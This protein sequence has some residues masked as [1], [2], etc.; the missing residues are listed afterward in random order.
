MLHL[1][2]AEAVRL[3]DKEM[4]EA[5]GPTGA[6]AGGSNHNL[7]EE[8]AVPPALIGL[9]AQR[10]QTG[11]LER[12]LKLSKLTEKKPAAKPAIV[13]LTKKTDKEKTAVLQQCLNVLLE[14]A[15]AAGDGEAVACLLPSYDLAV[16]EGHLQPVLPYALPAFA[17][18]AARRG[19]MASLAALKKAGA[20]EWTKACTGDWWITE[21]LGVHERMDCLSH[22]QAPPPPPPPPL[23]TGMTAASAQSPPNPAEGLL[24][25]G[26]DSLVPGVHQPREAIVLAAKR[27][28]EQTLMHLLAG[29]V[30]A[31]DVRRVAQA[32][33][34]EL[35]AALIGTDSAPPPNPAKDE[36]AR[37]SLA[38]AAAFLSPLRPARGAQRPGSA[39]YHPSRRPGSAEY[40]PSRRP[41][42]AEYH[43]S[44]RHASREQSEE[45]EL[46]RRAR[47]LLAGG[48]G[49]G[50]A[51]TRLGFGSSARLGSLADGG[52]PRRLPGSGASSGYLLDAGRGHLSNAHR[53]PSTLAEVN[54]GLASY[55][56]TLTEI[57]VSL[58]DCGV[59]ARGLAYGL[60]QRGFRSPSKTNT[61]LGAELE[62]QLAALSSRVSSLRD[63]TVVATSPGRTSP[64]KV[65]PPLQRPASLGGSGGLQSG[66]STS[67]PQ[68]W[69]QS[70]GL[71][72]SSSGA[73]LGSGER[74]RTA[75]GW[76]A[77]RSQGVALVAAAPRPE[78]VSAL[79]T[80]L[81]RYQGLEHA[82][83]DIRIPRPPAPAWRRDW[84]SEPAAATTITS[85]TTRAS[86]GAEAA[87]DEKLWMELLERSAGLAPL[88]RMA[89]LDQHSH[90]LDAYFRPKGWAPTKGAAGP[91][92]ARRRPLDLGP[93]PTAAFE[94]VDA[95][96]DSEA[97]QLLRTEL[98]TEQ[99]SPRAE[100]S[101]G[102]RSGQLHRP[103]AAAGS[104]A[105]APRHAARPS[106]PPQ[107]APQ[108]QLRV[109]PQLSSRAPPAKAFAV[110]GAPTGQLAPFQGAG[111]GVGQGVGGADWR[112]S[113]P[114]APREAPCSSLVGE[115]EAWGTGRGARAAEAAAERSRMDWGRAEWDDTQRASTLSELQAQQR[116]FEQQA[117]WLCGAPA[118]PAR[119]AGV[120]H[121]R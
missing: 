5:F 34:L 86:G 89:H 41:G 32:G 45:D 104:R 76:Q 24:R 25:E 8:A 30:D 11:L 20:V 63:G 37:A 46:L 87:A 10:G 81:P 35:L 120:R 21:Q 84:E 31:G 23:P 62:A 7:E 117:P 88:E 91:K 48:P 108:V 15:L 85:T 17:A 100:Q 22:L 33:D 107:V 67:G 119:S 2:L 14:A 68:S 101:S 42:S 72:G 118:Q 57:N 78:V 115:N 52:L 53:E 73:A 109:P 64:S 54:L 18:L 113:R 92:A 79:P 95:A 99:A 94:G 90:L 19:E 69:R 27:G 70:G 74:G 71:H 1:L 96:R 47:R 114:A 55:G 4:I 111:Q 106:R 97:E 29:T 28:D 61:M 65:A 75:A 39:D 103:R 49:G 3:G 44:R 50:L 43:S 6:S 59:S 121:M 16:T 38:P 77:E 83:P 58:A 56:S 36:A 51:P 40:H 112:P 93:E 26:G 116:D 60:S 80:T 9:V 82:P 66:F 102:Q 98:R 110:Q 13:A 105:A 12:L